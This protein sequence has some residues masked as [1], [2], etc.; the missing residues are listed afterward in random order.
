MAPVRIGRSS[1]VDLGRLTKALG[2]IKRRFDVV[3]DRGPARSCRLRCGRHR[4][5]EPCCGSSSGVDRDSAEAALNYL[6]VQL[7]RDFVTKF[8]SLQRN[9]SP[10]VMTI[11]DVPEELRRKFIG[12]SG[13]FLIQVHPKV[14]I[15]EQGGRA[16]VRHRA[17][18]GGS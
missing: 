15:W 17:A 16:A 18:L 10:T 14:D 1:P 13:H 12:Q 4:R 7:Y 6:Q 2:D 9:L 11:K 8:Y 5:P 3:A